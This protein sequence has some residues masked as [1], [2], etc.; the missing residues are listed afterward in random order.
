MFT[1]VE[2]NDQMKGLAW[3]FSKCS[4]EI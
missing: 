2:Q 1:Y 3:K 4:S